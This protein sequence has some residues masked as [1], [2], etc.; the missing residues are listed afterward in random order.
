MIK[1]TNCFPTPLADQYGIL[2]FTFPMDF[3]N[4]SDSSNFEKEKSRF[5]KL[6]SVE[7]PMDFFNN[8][9]S[10]NFEKEM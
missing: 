10:S 3:F 6:R 1:S 8:S 5:Q 7:V 2:Y 4:I 9:D